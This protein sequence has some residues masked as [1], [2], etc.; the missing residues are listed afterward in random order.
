MGDIIMTDKLKNANGK[1]TKDTITSRCKYTRSFY[2][3]TCHSAP[4]FI[5]LGNHEG[6]AGWVLSLMPIR[7]GNGLWVRNS[8]TG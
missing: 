3:A 4:L 7:D 2:E 1:I 8:M 6:E 5:T